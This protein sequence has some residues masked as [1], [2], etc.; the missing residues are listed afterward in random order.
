MTKTAKLYVV[1]P[2]YN[3]SEVLLETSKRLCQLFEELYTCKKISSDSKIIFVD[4]GSKDNTWQ[5]ITKS[6]ETYKWINGIKLSKNQGHQNALLAGL[7]TVKDE[8]DCTISIDADLQDDLNAIK[9]MIDKFLNGTDVVYGV[10]KKRSTDTFFKRTTALAFYKLMKFLGVNCI[11]NHADYRLMSKR[12]LDALSEFKEKNLFLRGIVPLVGFTSDCVYYDRNERFAGTSKYPFK[13]MLSFAFDGIT[14][15]SIT[16]I[17][18]ITFLGTATCFVSGI[19]L[20]YSLVQKFR[21]FTNPGWTS[22]IC[23]IWLLG[24]LQLLG[25]GLIGE[26]IGKVYKEV[27]DRPRYIIEEYLK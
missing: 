6:H 10:R 21:G 25:I 18:I 5:L 15:F 24:G 22:I 11:Y 19:I 14:S 4:D 27:K 7:L 12:A 26:Y 8:C 17:R 2:C 13:K 9:E 16:P 20:I 23:S 3:E 1:V